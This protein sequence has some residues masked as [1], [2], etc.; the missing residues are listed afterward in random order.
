M[1]DRN[2]ADVYSYFSFAYYYGRA[3]LGLS[4]R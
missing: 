3:H 4:A 2:F 1:A